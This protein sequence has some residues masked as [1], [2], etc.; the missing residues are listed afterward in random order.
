MENLRWILIAAGVAILVLLYFSGKPKRQNVGSRS[1]GFRA[2]DSDLGMDMGAHA[3]MQQDRNDDHDPLLGDSALDDAYPG[4]QETDDF[5]RPGTTAGGQSGGAALGGMP[6]SGMPPNDFS[7]GPA[8]DYDY[9]FEGLNAT[10]SQGEGA[11]SGFSSFTQKFE[12][13]GE[14]LSPKRRKLV[15]QSEPADLDELTV[16]DPKYANKI[17]MLHVVAPPESLLV[18]DHLLDVFER[19]GYHYGDMNIFHSMHEGTTV[20]SV[21]KMIEP[22]FFDIND[23]GSFET[24]GITMILQLPG[25]VPADVAFEVLV[26]EAYEMARELGGSVLDEQHSTLTK[27]T[28]Q[29]L[30]EGIYEYMH[31]QKYFGTVPS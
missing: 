31:R 3:G 17:V 18:G 9:E 7:H 27:Q 29:H 1:R 16:D 24:P 30:R 11:L 22:G 6:P 14:L 15:A 26:S 2:D 5:A 8:P 12:A 4:F 20:F 23:M 28:V 21:A 13:F 25:P 19:R 10:G